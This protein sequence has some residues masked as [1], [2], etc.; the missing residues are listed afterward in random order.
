MHRLKL[1]F[2][3]HHAKPEHVMMC[4]WLPESEEST[5]PIYAT[6]NIGVAGF[7]VNDRQELLVVQEKWLRNIKLIHWKL[8][9]GVADPGE[10]LWQTA[11]RET[12]EE[13][14]V[15]SEFVAV[16]CFRHMHGYL[17][18]TDDLYFACLLRPINTDIKIN[19]SEIA[20]A[21]WMDVDTY[22]ADPDTLAPNR[23]I[24]QSYKDGLAGGVFIK[25]TVY[26]AFI[27]GRPD[28]VMYNNKSHDSMASVAESHDSDELKSNI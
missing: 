18:G 17:W 7:V 9:G 8:P 19:P 14:G 1:G 24:A 27:Q 25:P 23:M 12:F 15:R 16:L 13:T 21:K 4:Q 20:D 11:I 5:L 22:I 28:Q 10:N 3:Y 2:K 6:H 26:P